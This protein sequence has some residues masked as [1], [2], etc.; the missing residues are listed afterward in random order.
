MTYEYQF[1]LKNERRIVSVQLVVA[2][3]Q[4]SVAIC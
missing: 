1:S 3:R 4:E 2:G